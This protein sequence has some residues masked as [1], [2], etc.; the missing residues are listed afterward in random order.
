MK[1]DYK[2]TLH[3]FKRV[4]VGYACL[5]KVKSL[6]TSDLILDTDIFYLWPTSVADYVTFWTLVNWG[7][8]QFKTN[9][10]LQFSLNVQTF[11]HRGCSIMRFYLVKFLETDVNLHMRGP[12]LSSQERT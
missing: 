6:L 2:S 12:R 1:G 5:Q 7:S 8:G 11:I 9:G 10:T 3:K 4:N